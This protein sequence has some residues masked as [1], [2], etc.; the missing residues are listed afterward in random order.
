MGHGVRGVGVWDSES[1]RLRVTVTQVS[2]TRDSERRE[3]GEWVRVCDVPG[4][5]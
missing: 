1:E 4:L 5:H 3:C 2:R